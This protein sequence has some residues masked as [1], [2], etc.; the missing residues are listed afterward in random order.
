M[1]QYAVKKNALAYNLVGEGLKNHK[2]IPSKG[3]FMQE[4]R[5]FNGSLVFLRM[6]YGFQPMIKVIDEKLKENYYYFL[7]GVTPLKTENTSGFD[8][9]F[10]HAQ[11]N[12]NLRH[13]SYANPYADSALMNYKDEYPQYSS[14]NANDVVNNLKELTPN[15]V[16][17]V[18]QNSNTKMTFVEWLNS[19]QGKDSV[20]NVTALAF[21]LL[22]N[23]QGGVN[24]TNTTAPK[25]VKEDDKEEEFRILW[26]HPLTFAAVSIVAIVGSMIAFSV[27][28]NK[29]K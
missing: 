12:P 17:N 15:Q 29:N 5:K 25:P 13:Y 27:I 7:E 21:S 4:D 8:A 10:I 20:N 18:Y 23:Q 26:M 2:L 3:I 6:P 22:N 14:A 1:E 28:K 11:R 16:Q 9:N 24:P 19:P